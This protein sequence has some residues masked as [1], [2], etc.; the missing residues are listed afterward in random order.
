MNTIEAFFNLLGR[1][2]TRGNRYLRIAI[3]IILAF[4]FFALI[5]SLANLSWLTALLVV[6]IFVGAACY[7]NA[8]ILHPLLVVAIA[9]TK[10][11]KEI[12]GSIGVMLG[13]EI[14]FTIY[15]VLVPVAKN[16]SLIPAFLL[17][18]LALIVFSSDEGKKHKKIKRILALLAIGIT[19]AFFLPDL[20]RVAMAK[21]GKVNEAIAEMEP[22]NSLI[23]PGGLMETAKDNAEYR[24]ALAATAAMTTEGK[25]SSPTISRELLST[26]P[27]FNFDNK[28]IRFD[29]GEM[30]KFISLEPGKTSPKIKIP[31]GP[32]WRM[33]LIDSVEVWPEHGSKYMDV[34][35]VFHSNGERTFRITG[36]NTVRIELY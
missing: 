13:F 8:V 29:V 28:E 4:P 22:K 19:A 25:S 34:P 11:G 3:F 9:E 23:P 35:G 7:L 31:N 33:R 20:P 6:L 26:T 16:I 27:D 18:I 32:G 1:V 2:W 17:V 21:I 24:D 12:L 5:V 15:C 30:T 14:L 36:R 10:G